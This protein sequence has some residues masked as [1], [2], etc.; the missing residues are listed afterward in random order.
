MRVAK[1]CVCVC[2]KASAENDCLLACCM[3]E[4]GKDTEVFLL[5]QSNSAYKFPQPTVWNIAQKCLQIKSYS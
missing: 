4:A 3:R 5:G 1:L 2:V